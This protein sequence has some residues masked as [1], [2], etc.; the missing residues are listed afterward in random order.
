MTIASSHSGEG[1]TTGICERGNGFRVSIKQGQF[2]AKGAATVV[3]SQATFCSTWEPLIHS[4]VSCV[5]EFGM[6]QGEQV[7]TFPK[8]GDRTK[9]ERFHVSRGHSP[10]DT[11][12]IFAALLNTSHIDRM[13]DVIARECAGHRALQLVSVLACRD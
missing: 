9:L 8:R 5:M 12:G 1:P 7:D 10:P 2:L 11:S 13:N 6:I 4:A 3:T